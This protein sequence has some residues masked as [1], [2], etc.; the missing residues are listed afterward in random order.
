MQ[1]SLH[2]LCQC[3]GNARFIACQSCHGSRK[4]L[5]HHFKYNSIALRCTKCDKNDG[6]VQCP[7]CLPSSSAGKLPALLQDINNNDDWASRP[8]RKLELN[9]ET[10]QNNQGT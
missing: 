4:S 2:E 10:K 6:I 9:E 7:A 5:V 8:D 1:R 3:C